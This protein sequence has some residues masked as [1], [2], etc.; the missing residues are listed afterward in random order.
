MLK[1]RIGILSSCLLLC[2][3]GSFGWAAQKWKKINSEYCEIYFLSYSELK[4]INS[5][6]DVS[7][8]SLDFKKKIINSKIKTKSISE[9]VKRKFDIIFRKAEEIL[10]MYPRGINVKI[11]IYLNQKQLNR[12]YRKMFKGENKALSFYIY[13][14]N[15]I[16]IS[17]EHI[18]EGVLAHEMGHCIIDHY[19]V[20]LP[21]RNVQE[22]LAI[23]VDT[24]LKD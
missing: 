18:S 1:L 16:Y 6:V 19:F 8:I 14:T 23:Y 20:I 10:N 13:K 3:C 7:S 4:K 17:T 2:W 9:K 11:R 12:V 15:T 21:P 5:N 24:H 22:I